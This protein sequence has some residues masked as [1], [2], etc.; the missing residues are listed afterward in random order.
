MS[1]T[2]SRIFINKDFD[3]DIFKTVFKRIWVV[4]LIL[5]LLSM[6]TAYVYLRYT[7]SIFQSE[8]L[9]QITKEDTGK[10]VID[11]EN[12]NSNDNI[13]EEIELLRSQLLF[14]KAIQSLN[15]HVSHYSKGSILTEEKYIQSTFN[16]R[17]Y[18]LFDSTLCS[19]PL[20]LRSKG[21]DISSLILE[22]IHL[23][24]K[25]KIPVNLD[26]RIKNEFF[27]IQI[28]ASSLSSFEQDLSENELYFIF[29]DPE[30]LSDKY[31]PSL[32]ITPIDL[33]AKTIE[34]A[35]Q[36][37]NA[38]L[39]RDITSAVGAAFFAYDN[40]IQKE[41]SDKILAFISNQ[42]DSL[43]TEVRASRDS[44][45]NFQR[46]ENIPDPESYTASL[47]TNLTKLQD[48]L[49]ELEDEKYTLNLIQAKLESNVNRLEIYK[50][51]PALYNKSFENILGNQI[52]RLLEK[53]ERREDLLFNVTE[54]STSISNL[55]Q[56]I[57]NDIITIGK[58]IDAIAERIESKKKLT[59]S[60]LAQY[61]KEYFALPE[62]KIEL[63]R[64]KNL[65]SLNEKYYTLLTEKKVLYSI[66]N[67]GYTSNNKILRKAN[68]PSNPISPNHTLVYSSFIFFGLLIGLFYL[69]YRYVSYNEINSL[70]DLK[71]ILPENANILGAVPFYKKVM[72][73]S[74]LLI[75]DAPKSMIA[76]AMRNIRSNLTFVNPDAKLIAISS[77]ISGEGKTFVA[78]NLA[79]II[80]SSGKKTIIVDLDLRKPKI[81]LGG[82]LDNQK[83]VSNILCETY[84]VAECVKKTA[85]EG[86]DII[87]AGPVPPNPSELILSARFDAFLEQLKREYDIVIIDN[88][89][90][91]IVSDGIKTLSIAD[92][93]IYIFKANYSGRQFVEKV[94]DLEKIQKIKHLN[95]I[96][97][98]LKVTKGKYGYGYGYG[99]YYEEENQNKSI[100]KRVFKK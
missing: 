53:L 85:I 3:P 49:F 55:N 47:N 32:K 12:I 58:T 22:F 88:P 30:S 25:H 48:M 36:S 10:Q 13:S 45:T 98:G 21:N 51:L 56:R 59:S 75:A 74:Q 23:G 78:L 1:N 4:I 92:I 71:K 5:V 39:S 83:G 99:G 43:S 93:P 100:F 97:N 19:V 9:I 11:F 44:I 67:A 2:T 91:G 50:L 69:F 26:E 63:T 66:S 62:K 70:D 72:K 84:T 15:M 52:E 79:G 34:I 37:N 54:K 42:L 82:N 31:L 40:N 77:S 28:K 73:Y 57:E 68:L 86:L 33:S 20:Y 6:A 61:E 27:D 95:V 8:M 96:L 41:S 90:V 18:D 29:N 87:T 80:A 81:H 17:V 65:E 64:L 89:P 94:N 35:Y 38:V 76:E 14:N 24:E 46:Q 7:K 16:V 60:Q